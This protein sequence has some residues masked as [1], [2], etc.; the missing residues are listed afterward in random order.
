MVGQIMTT[1][2]SQAQEVAF[3]LTRFSLSATPVWMQGYVIA[4][5]IAGS[6]SQGRSVDGKVHLFIPRPQ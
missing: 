5:S 1:P 2:I 3:A 4:A 6:L